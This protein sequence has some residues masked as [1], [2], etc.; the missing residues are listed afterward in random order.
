M[1]T[2]LKTKTKQNKLKPKQQHCQ[3]G[4]CCGVGQ[5][6]AC[7]VARG[8]EVTEGLGWLMNKKERGPCLFLLPYNISLN[9]HT[10]SFHFMLHVGVF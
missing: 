1:G 5:I 10:L 7:L 6:A 4:E 3:Q 8:R 2:C 9:E